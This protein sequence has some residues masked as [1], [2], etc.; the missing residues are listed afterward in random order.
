M[1]ATHLALTVALLMALTAC[2]K[3]PQGEAGP[4]GPQGPQGQA[5]P[6]GPVGPPGPA[7][8]Q[9]AAG[10][11]G[12][13]GTNVRIVRSD[14]A[15]GSACTMECRSDEVLVTAYCGPNR[16]QAQFLAERGASCGP[17]DTGTNTPLVAVCAGP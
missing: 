16:G 13:V 17:V 12:P 4:A 11:A 3:G 1:R 14:C 9:G 15:S 6:V 10:P 7:G 8:P 5:G 2:S